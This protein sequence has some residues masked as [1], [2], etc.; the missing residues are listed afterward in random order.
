MTIVV[1]VVV[2]VVIGYCCCCCC[3]I[4]VTPKSMALLLECALCNQDYKQA[5]SLYHKYWEECVE[6]TVRL[7]ISQFLISTIPP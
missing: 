2:V 3:R 1:V 7:F 4:K 6:L 5:A